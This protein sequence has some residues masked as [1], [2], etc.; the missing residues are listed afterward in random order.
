MKKVLIGCD[1]GKDGFI[2]A[3]DG[4]DLNSMQCLIIK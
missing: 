2:T 1:P 3:F 4:V